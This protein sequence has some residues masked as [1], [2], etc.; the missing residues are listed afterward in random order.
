MQ[1]PPTAELERLIVA[2]WCEVLGLE[3]VDLHANFFD[4]GGNS[5]GMA[6]VHMRLRGTI[7][8][9]V[10]LTELFELPTVAALVEH[11]DGRRT[12]I[13]ALD[14]AAGTDPAEPVPGPPPPPRT[15]EA[16]LGADDIAI[17]GMACHV[18]G[19]DGLDAFWQ[20]LRSGVESIRSLSD[21]ELDRL[22]VPA[23]RRRHPNFVNA[24]ALLSGVSM[25]D[26]AFWGY[27][28]REAALL[29]PQQRLFLETVWEA[30]EHAGYDPHSYDGAIGVY[31]G[32]GMSRYLLRNLLGHPEVT[33]ADS[34]MLLM[35]N[36]KDFLTTRVSYHLNLR[37]PSLAVQTGCS[38]S[39]VAA[40][41]A[42]RALANQECDMALV[43]GVTVIPPQLSGY[44]RTPGST[45]SPDGHSRAFD[46][47]AAGTVFG[48]GVG[49]IV[50]KRLADALAQRDTV[51]AIIKGSAVNNDGGNKVGFAAPGITGQAEVIARAH[52]A[53]GVDPRTITYVEAHGTATPLGDPAEVAALTRAFRTGTDAVGFC[54]LGA[55]KGNVGHLDTASGVVG[56]IKTTLALR[57]RQIPPSLHFEHPNPEIDF[58]HSP[59]HVNTGLQDWPQGPTPRRA[60]VSSFGFGGTN[61]HVVLEEPPLR[62]PTPTRDR[63]QVLLLSARTADALDR[64]TER[65]AEHLRSAPEQSLADIA[66][67]SQVGR[68]RFQHRRSVLCRDRE[69]AVAALSTAKHSQRRNLQANR[70]GR[71]VAFMFS[72]IG[73]QYT[74]MTQDLYE[75]QPLFASAIDE[76]AELLQPELGCDLR[77]L[78]YPARPGLSGAGP[79]PR[80]NLDM[81]ALLGGIQPDDTLA[82]ATAAYPAV[83]AVEYALARQL[84]AWGVQ[85]TAL[86]GHSLGEYTA[87]TLAGVFTLKDAL[88]LVVR[89]AR[90]ID[91]LPGGAMLA[92]S[93][94]AD[95][96]RSRVKGTG[97]SVALINGPRLTVAGGTAPEINALREQ[98]AA[99]DIEC[100]ALSTR[101]A[102]HTPAL[103]PVVGPFTDAVRAVKLSPPRIPLM[104]NAT[105]TWMTA[106]DAT[107]PEY[108]G[109]QTV[110]TVDFAGGIGELCADRDQVL[111]ELGPGQ[112]LCSLAADH[113]LDSGR[114]VDGLVLSSLRAWYDHRE[115]DT[116][117][118]H[119]LMGRLWLAGVDVDWA[120]V[121]APSPPGRVP[122]PHYP[123]ERSHIWLDPPPK[124]PPTAGEAVSRVDDP[125]PCARLVTGTW[126]SLP[127]PVVSR[128]AAAPAPPE[129]W[130]VL[131][132]AL[133]IAS[134]LMDRLTNEGL[135]T[136]LVEA[137]TRFERISDHH[138][139][140]VPD[141]AE[142]HGRLADALRRAG[143]VPTHI[144]HLWGLDRATTEPV[145]G[146]D[147]PDDLLGLLSTA[148]PLAAR[149]EDEV[150]VERESLHC[151]VVSNGLAAIGNGDRVRTGS[152]ALRAAA[153][154]ISRRHPRVGVHLLDV[155]APDL[156]DA[157]LVARRLLSVVRERP[158]PHAAERLIAFRG[159]RRWLPEIEHLAFPASGT[160]PYPLRSRGVCLITDGLSPLALALAEGLAR[161]AHSR[162]ALLTH[163]DFP[164]PREWPAWRAGHNAD[165]PTSRR[166]ERLTALREQG[167]DILVISTDVTDPTRMGTALAE[168][169]RTLGP[170]TSLIGGAGEKSPDCRILVDLLQDAELD[171]GL[172]LAFGTETPD[173]S[174]LM[175]RRTDNA[176]HDAVA[177]RQRSRCGRRWISVGFEESVNCREPVADDRPSPSIAPA[178]A[179]RVLLRIVE[180]C[181]EPQV[182]VTARH[183]EVRRD[184]LPIGP[185]ANTVPLPMASLDRQPR[186]AL[187]TPFAA[188]EGETE[189]SIAEIWQS[190]LGIQAVGRDDNFHALGGH[191]LL[192]TQVVAR[193]RSMYGIDLPMVSL[194]GAPTVALFAQRVMRTPTAHAD[195]ASG[196]STPHEAR[197]AHL[198]KAGRSPLLRPVGPRREH[199]EFRLFC[200]P[201]AGGGASV[202]RKWGE[203]LPDHMEPWAVQL[204]GREDRLAEEPIDDLEL[205]VDALDQA[206]SPLLD[207]PFAFFGHSMGAIV[208]WRLTDRLRTARKVHPA[209][210]F[211]SGCRPPTHARTEPL[212][213]QLPDT[214]LIGEL[215]TMGATPEEILSDPE[216]AQLFLP[217]I[218]A[219]LAAT[220]SYQA[221][222]RRPMGRVTAFAGTGDAIVSPEQLRRWGELTDGPFDLEEFP[223]G[224]L[225]LTDNAK[226]VVAR[227]LERV[228]P[229]TTHDVPYLPEGKHT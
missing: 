104:S 193:V 29:D 79:R 162:L 63:P 159:D 147:A 139:R 2:A 155:A 187:E 46:A 208:A 227:I 76:C 33:D 223:G 152:A 158:A 69:E 176:L 173:T 108:W 171:F 112:A 188:P 183:Q 87:A 118:L 43:G 50:L 91:E 57:H 97:V 120:A 85:P 28:P 137:G 40:H 38:T 213:H 90:L 25:F 203:W 143:L 68:V 13:S 45:A 228:D 35:G 113:L 83:F 67:T 17:V 149:T 36:D 24:A 32:M 93:L 196:T 140:M 62:A 65:L 169:A 72:G 34:P 182:T 217:T 30:L 202:F 192:A 19:A 211:V 190:L 132:D 191:S 145:P 151:W 1:V 41:L 66:Y 153:R 146:F 175:S 122:L 117:L 3:S 99:E 56:L 219:D 77:E 127:F 70:Q 201:Y 111:V 194:F 154:Q 134:C 207:R 23:E 214:E 161:Q 224:H 124:A 11:L 64:A 180:W 128:S 73:D 138:Y 37:G 102:F 80:G 168:V 197:S 157:A 48:N 89:R 210:V 166:I 88:H 81:A 199:P 47:A 60:G 200:F 14:G 148:S 179:A 156:D 107:D 121:H 52:R 185:G 119:D 6:Q 109:R 163:E 78:L 215:R 125:D 198:S 135:P 49:V 218:R 100:R 222:G 225:F 96:L 123:F 101:Y 9:E 20:N 177:L 133:G 126:R 167:T 216:L 136:V 7:G 51:H 165:D 59:F 44:I 106:R 55:V 212:W 4:L 94:P 141:S 74:G 220:E 26:H 195:T 131:A 226:A 170:V 103:D 42:A 189:T 95:A 178:D 61:A 184:G 160:P 18:P 204:P 10:S 181:D 110:R 21:D 129:R 229:Q 84:A 114:D 142:D 22:R 206:L 150:N 8:F 186:P 115:S 174:G 144:A 75:D 164:A 54:A 130:L 53:A 172:L 5:L 221:P 71:S 31:A 205:M 86:I 16:P 116:A 58:E 105:G 27:S 209:H 82:Q 12:G 98:L 92:V 15:E 39:L